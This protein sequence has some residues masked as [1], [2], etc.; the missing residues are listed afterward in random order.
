MNRP[1]LPPEALELARRLGAQSRPAPGFVH[2]TQTGRMRKDAAARWMRYSAKQTI[3]TRECGFAWQARAGT[4]GLIQIQDSLLG[5]VGQLRVSALGLIPIARAGRSAQLTRGQLMRYLAELA[6]APDAVVQNPDL[7]WRAEAPDRLVVGAGEGETSAEVRLT[8]DAEGRIVSTF[9]PDRLRS[10]GKSFV[11]T[12]WRGR[13]SD[14]RFHAG[15]WLPFRAEV[16]WV[17]DGEDV[18]CWEGQIVE[19]RATDSDAAPRSTR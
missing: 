12:P 15:L 1:S 2:L 7:R 5:G 13:F 11:P 10:V 16:A 4:A 8:L 6:W 3:F 14:Y 9:A 18:V 17:I 19:W